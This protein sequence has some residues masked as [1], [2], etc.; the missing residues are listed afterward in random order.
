MAAVGLGFYFYSRVNDEIRQ[1]VQVLWQEHYPG[2][3]VTVRSAQLV[4]GEGIEIRGLSLLDPNAP[5]PR[6]E[7]AYIDE[8][9]LKCQTSLP[10]LVQGTPAFTRA[11]IRR[12]TINATRRP[13]G[14]WSAA[15]LLPIPKFSKHPLEVVIEG[16]SIEFFDPLKNPPSTLTLRDV[17]LQL[18]PIPSQAPSERWATEV[19]GYLG[20]DHFQRIEIRSGRIEPDLHGWDV[21]GVLTGLD[22]S[23]E[24]RDTLPVDIGARLVALDPLRGQVRVGFHLRD[25]PAAP[26]TDPAQR[27]QFQLNGQLAAG[28]FDDPRL[29]YPLTELKIKFQADNRGLKI[30][31]L[32]TRAGQATLRL[33]GRLDG[34]QPGA[35]LSLDAEAEHLLLGP[36]WEPILPD[37]LLAEWRRF[38]PAG[39][40]NVKNLH[41][42]FD[43][44]Q[45][46]PRLTIECVDGS[47]SYFK[48]PYRMDRVKGTLVLADNRLTAEL[49]AFAASR[50]LTITGEFENPGQRFTGGVQ[51]WGELPFDENL[52]AAMSPK[53]R[54]AVRALNPTGTFGF[55]FHVTRPDPKSAG[56]ALSF[57]QAEADFRSATRNFPFRF[58]T[59]AATW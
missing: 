17:N 53:A 15:R 51:A 47:F 10:E 9:V 44:R 54:E 55:Y 39:E 3:V 28:R 50:P 14:T 33:S 59:S 40:V 25:N 45:W 58:T 41:L 48:F 36:Q 4:D 31:E 2:L 1:R 35:P 46:R 32:T 22:I 42:E 30:D 19:R 49:T 38:Q 8:I 13:D 26:Q 29:P 21:S 16:G 23:P 57:G 11:L 12:P 5:G 24:L 20:G 6:A 43:G 18:K 37:G 56:V 27:I 7:L 52:L 34:F